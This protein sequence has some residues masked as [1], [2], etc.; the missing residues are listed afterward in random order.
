[1]LYKI[2]PFKTAKVFNQKTGTQ[3]RNDGITAKREL[4]GEDK[5][6]FTI[7]PFSDYRKRKNVKSN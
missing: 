4:C 2:S 3:R 5:L 6:F 1:M 7:C